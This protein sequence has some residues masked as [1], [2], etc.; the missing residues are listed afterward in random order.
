VRTN[1]YDSSTGEIANAVALENFSGWIWGMDVID[2]T[3][4]VL[5]D[6]RDDGQGPHIAAFDL[7]TGDAIPDTTLILSEPGLVRGLSCVR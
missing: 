4:L 2:G 7:L 3:L 6:G 1:V 5:G